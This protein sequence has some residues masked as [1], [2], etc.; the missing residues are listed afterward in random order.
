MSPTRGA[1]SKLDVSTEVQRDDSTL[2]RSLNNLIRETKSNTLPTLFPWYI[3]ASSQRHMRYKSSRC[4]E[5]RAGQQPSLWSCADRWS[6]PPACMSP[7]SHGLFCDVSAGTSCTAAFP[8]HKVC[9]AE[10]LTGLAM[11]CSSICQRSIRKQWD[12]HLWSDCAHL[13]HRL[14]HTRLQRS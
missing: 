9:S 7:E 3:A 2:V 8:W 6:F 11:P 4:V 5:G 13:C 1:Q 10:S 12:M 14:P